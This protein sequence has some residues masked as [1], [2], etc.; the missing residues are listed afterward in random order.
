MVEK[1]ERVVFWYGCNAIRHGDIIHSAMAVLRAVGIESDATGGPGYCCG[2]SKDGNLAA[3]AGMAA[4]TVEKFNATGRDKVVTWC[5]SCHRHMGTF[6]GGVNPA[7]FE[8]S[9]ITEMLHARRH[10]LAPLLTHPLERRV[11]LHA[12]T[13]F[14]EVDAY[15]LVA[16]LLRLIPGL[17]L[18]VTD[19]AAPGHMCSALAAVPQALKDVV[20]ESVDLCAAHDSDTLV[21]VFHS[22]QR[23]LCGLATT[24]GINVV[25]YVNLLSDAIGIQPPPDEYAEWKN[26]GSE[27]AI[28]ASV[29]PDRIAKIGADFFA[30]QVLPELRKLPEK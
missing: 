29:G 7:K 23:L 27:A 12:H 1:R 6:M 24:D 2:T 18:V 28:M 14:H 22:C 8:V 25:N 26:A 3:A 19:F 13:G 10:L 9:H 15:P 11:V 16:D 17:D 30:K 20:R 5:P 21:T 4:R